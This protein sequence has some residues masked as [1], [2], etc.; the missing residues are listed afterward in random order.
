MKK[1]PLITVSWID[2]SAPQALSQWSIEEAA[3]G[4]R[5]LLVHT[6]GT[7]MVDTPMHIILGA[8]EHEDGEYRH[9]STIPKV[10]IVEVK[11]LNAVRTTRKYHSQK[12]YRQGGRAQQA[13]QKV[14]KGSSGRRTRLASNRRKKRK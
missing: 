11:I 12:G 14:S 9:T 7:L 6:T 2:A 10:N 3:L 5:P 13:A 1:H 4:L 8:E